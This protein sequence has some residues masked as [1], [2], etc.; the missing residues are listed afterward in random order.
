VL[1]EVKVVGAKENLTPVDVAFRWLCF[2]S[3]LQEGDA[4]I[5][6]GIG[7]FSRFFE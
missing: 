6:G 4:I 5:V 1:E 3:L 7:I 2:H